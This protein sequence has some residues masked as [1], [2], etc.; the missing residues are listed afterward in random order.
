MNKFN[1]IACFVGFVLGVTGL[2]MVLVALVNPRA[3]VY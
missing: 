2:P 1:R 3:S